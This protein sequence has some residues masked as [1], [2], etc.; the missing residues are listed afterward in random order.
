M[1]CLFLVFFLIFCLNSCD[2]IRLAGERPILRVPDGNNDRMEKRLFSGTNE[3]PKYWLARVTVTSK[4]F[5]GGDLGGAVFP[6]FQNNFKAGYFEFER[7]QMVFC[8]RVSRKFLENER[9]GRQVL[10][11][12]IYAWNITHSS[13]RLAEV[14]GW[15][16]NREEEN[17]YIS[18]DQKAYFKTAL[19]QTSLNLEIPINK[20][21]WNLKTMTLDDKSRVIQE[22]YISFIAIAT[23]EL[24]RC[25]TAK[26]YNENN[27]TGTVAYK[28]SF[29]K[30]PDPL[31][32]DS[33]YKPYQYTGENDPLKDK[34]GYFTTTKPDFQSDRR[35]KNLFYMN[36]WNPNKKHTFYFTKDYPDEYKYIAHGVICNTNKM[37]GKYGLNDYPLDGACESDGSVL[38][39]NDETCS[40][41]ICFELKDNQGQELGDIRYSFFHLT[42][43]P[44]GVLGYGPSNAHPATGEIVNG[45]VVIGTRSLDFSINQTME[46]IADEE[47]RYHTSPVLSSITQILK[48]TDEEDT[49]RQ[50][51]DREYWTE[52]SIPL[53]ENRNLFNWF[54]SFF[55]FANPRFS[56]FTRASLHNH[57]IEAHST[58]DFLFSHL[59]KLEEYSHLKDFSD[60]LKVLKADLESGLNE[61][62]A[63]DFLIR[64]SLDPS[65]PTQG[66]IYFFDQ[67]DTSVLNLA[68]QGLSK[69]EIK[70]KVLFS[71]IS[72][73]FGHVLNLRHNF[74]GSVDS[75]HYH[76]HAKTSSV[77]DYT[78]MK[79][80]VD[81]PDWAYFGPYDEAALVY[82]Y[83]D[84]RVDLSE[85]NETH[86]LFCQDQDVSLNF[87]CRRFDYG[88]TVSKVTQNLIESYD[89]YYIFRNFRDGRAYWDQRFYPLAIQQTMYEIKRPLALLNTFIERKEILLA[90]GEDVDLLE[91]DLKQ[92]VKLSLSFYN[93]IIQLDDRQRSWH[94]T[95]NPVTGSLESIGILTDKI[96]ATVFLM[97]DF[98]ISE[99]PNAPVWQTSY[100]PYINDPHLK[101]II[102][103][104]MENS[105]TRRIDTVPGFT[106]LAKVL[107]SENSA[108]F[109]NK[110]EIPE[111]LEKIGVRC[112]TQE[113]LRKRFDVDVVKENGSLDTL[114]TLRVT[115]ALKDPYYK[116]L[117]ETDPFR[118]MDQ[119]RLFLG[120]IYYHGN[121]YTSL[122]EINDYSF[123][124]INN[125]IKFDLSEQAE[126]QSRED[127]YFLYKLYNSSKYSIFSTIECDDGSQ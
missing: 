7:D 116:T 119:G 126:R 24:D 63:S 55:H 118:D 59:E 13:F 22:D 70:E 100:L 123:S 58:E 88:D 2:R 8:N 28:Y 93:A 56:V 112:Y 31:R 48:E 12:K 37:F 95:Y 120:V 26:R 32:P 17:N 64:S 25:G 19:H 69:E 110:R 45:T 43:I 77:M 41:G 71:L 89:E 80:D 53:S 84:G 6:G 87:L 9:T 111:A 127:V 92:A 49:H 82:A 27:R 15:T 29:K 34:Y 103:T 50:L 78:V 115:S 76:D 67:W 18:W 83:S 47:H 106:D 90:L 86:Y 21:C 14:D 124:I 74:Y 81:S 54:V 51:T 57:G 75:K 79:D 65:D 16:T 85:E 125:L 104:V 61:I 98:S 46:L 11:D 68:K 62:N 60:D 113:G 73:E 99:D 97:S 72:H 105:L 10:C 102:D 36:R 66:T 1:R 101:D 30:I 33:H 121:Y 96:F 109:F 20:A 107:Y 44:I 108:N 117:L 52:S 94:N 40:R 122:S 3:D 23:Y 91:Q 114:F 42:D 35:D 39:K 4:S 38:P 5:E